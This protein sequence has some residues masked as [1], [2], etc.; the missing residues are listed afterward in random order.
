[1][2]VNMCNA[3]CSNLV[4]PV[5]TRNVVPIT[6]TTFVD[7]FDVVVSIMP[8]LSQY[9][10][11]PLKLWYSFKHCHIMVPVV[12]STCKKHISI[13]TYIQNH[14]GHCMFNFFLN[15]TLFVSYSYYQYIHLHLEMKE[16]KTYVKPYE[17]E[18]IKEV[19]NTCPLKNR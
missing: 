10:L 7:F 14:H 13:N 3:V 19:W 12:S 1:M 2:F 17:G 15:V 11:L 8:W 4:M 9:F 16:S 18:C 5:L 6:V